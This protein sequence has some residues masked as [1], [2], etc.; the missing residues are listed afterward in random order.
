MT[1]PRKRFWWPHALYEV[2]PAVCMALG[3]VMGLASLADA[4]RVGYWPT[5]GAGVLALGCV[6][7]FYGGITQ[8]L[9]GEYRRRQRAQHPGPPAP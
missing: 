1:A 3:A 7:A 4:I 5:A 6:F 2:R 9:R 8:Q